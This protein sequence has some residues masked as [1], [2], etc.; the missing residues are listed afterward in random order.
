MHVINEIY[1]KINH[2]TNNWHKDDKE[3]TIPKNIDWPYPQSSIT[4]YG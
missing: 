4:H 1:I 2:L 3:R